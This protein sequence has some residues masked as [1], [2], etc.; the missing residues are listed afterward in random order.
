MFGRL[1]KKLSGNRPSRPFG[2]VWL[3]ALED[4]FGEVT[5]I[6]EMQSEGKPLIYIF[7]FDGLPEQGFLTAVTCGLSDAD[8]PDWK[9]GKPELIVTMESQDYSWGLAAGYF[10]SAFFGEKRFSYGDVF[11]VDTPLSTESEMN[12]F[13]LFAPSFLDK[14]Q[15]RFVLPDRVV[16]LIGLYPLYD[17]EIS[18]YDRIGLKDFWHADGFDMSNPRRGRVNVA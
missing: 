7:Y 15:F 12:S 6:K 18:V 1:F 4:Q 9:F 5:Q 8:Y 10:A 14:E 2:E 17:S 3:E 16:N 13:L 11:K